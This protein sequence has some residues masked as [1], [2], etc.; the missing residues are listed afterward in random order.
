MPEDTNNINQITT[1][2]PYVM[3]LTSLIINGFVFLLINGPLIFELLK[4]NDYTNSQDVITT[5]ILMKWLKLYMINPGINF[6]AMYLISALIVGLV[7]QMASQSISLIIGNTIENIYKRRSHTKFFFSVAVFKSAD[8][9]KFMLWL[10]EHK[11]EKWFWEW[12]LFFYNISWGLTTNIFVLFLMTLI[13]VKSIDFWLIILAIIT[14]VLAYYS[15]SRSE[16]LGK[17]HSYCREKMNQ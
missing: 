4:G 14:L 5:G 11:S 6:L 9:S 13:L 15:L 1:T 12:E 3:V 8:Y 10:L 16:I 7:V 17:V 2:F